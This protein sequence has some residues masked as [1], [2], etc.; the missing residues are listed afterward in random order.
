MKS[1]PPLIDKATG[2]CG[3]TFSNDPRPQMVTIETY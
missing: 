1:L 2:E 3:T